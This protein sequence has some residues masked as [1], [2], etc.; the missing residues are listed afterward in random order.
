MKEAIKVSDK[1]ENKSDDDGSESESEEDEDE[2]RSINSGISQASYDSYYE[3]GNQ[4]VEYKETIEKGLDKLKA[5][6]MNQDYYANMA[7]FISDESLQFCSDIIDI[8]PSFTGHGA[9]LARAI[10]G[11]ILLVKQVT[12]PC[13]IL[14]KTNHNKIKCHLRMSKN[15]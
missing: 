7:Q 6:P 8:Q 11:S 14:H 15:N 12:N 10:T 5:A 4:F 13:L 3:V 1:E 9:N 2:V